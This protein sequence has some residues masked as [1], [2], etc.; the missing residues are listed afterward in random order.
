VNENAI[1]DQELFTRIRERVAVVRR[2][3]RARAAHRRLE[4]ALGDAHA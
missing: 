3:E 4:L 1:S 2:S